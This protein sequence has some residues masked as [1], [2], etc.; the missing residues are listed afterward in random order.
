MNLWNLFILN[1]KDSVIVIYHFFYTFWLI[2]WWI[3]FS[4]PFLVLNA[5]SNLVCTSI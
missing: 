2:L 3:C 4:S 1:L 5:L